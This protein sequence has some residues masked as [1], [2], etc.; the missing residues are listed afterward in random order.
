MKVKSISFNDNGIPKEDSHCICLS[1][2]LID[3][4]FKKNNSYYPLVFLEEDKYIVKEKKGSRFITDVVEIFAHDSDEEY[5][6]IVNVVL[7]FFE[8]WCLF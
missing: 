7:E 1:V 6:L 3:F 4:V 8:S 5:I 2:I